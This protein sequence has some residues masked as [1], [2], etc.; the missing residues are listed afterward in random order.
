MRDSSNHLLK[1]ISAY[2]AQATQN[3]TQLERVGLINQAPKDRRAHT[4]PNLMRLSSVCL[5]E[6]HELLPVLP[7]R[8]N[9][10]HQRTW[11]T[12]ET[13]WSSK[14]EYLVPLT[15]VRH[16]AQQLYCAAHHVGGVDT[17]SVRVIGGTSKCLNEE[18]GG[19]ASQDVKASRILCRKFAS[20]IYS[21]RSERVMDRAP[22]TAITP[23][24]SAWVTIEHRSDSTRVPN[25]AITGIAYC[26]HQWG[27]LVD[28]RIERQLEPLCISE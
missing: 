12:L 18:R 16:A 26:R 28:R 21:S 17:L 8:H 4:G 24:E 19:I 14:G 27:H 10:T 15:T 22:T 3:L 20:D 11:H 2:T 7:R 13:I 5:I 9:R 1:Q 6:V 23:G 25:T